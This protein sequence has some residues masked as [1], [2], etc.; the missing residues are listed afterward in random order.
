MTRPDFEKFFIGL[1]TF[2]NRP[3]F[4]TK[5]EY[6]RYN[7]GKVENGYNIMVA[8][9]GWRREDLKV[10]LHE[11]TLTVAG[12][13]KKEDAEHVDWQ[14]KGISGKSFEKM[15]GISQELEVKNI[16]ELYIQAKVLNLF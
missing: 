12:L 9:P 5:I 7:I 3:Q 2:Y 13:K 15:F 16:M 1:D 8:L 11:G 14:H 10:T 4:T 6:P